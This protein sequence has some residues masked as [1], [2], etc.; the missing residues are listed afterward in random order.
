MNNFSLKCSLDTKKTIQIKLLFEHG[1]QT[2]KQT[3]HSHLDNIR[4]NWFSPLRA[5]RKKKEKF[6]KSSQLPCQ[7]YF[8]FRAFQQFF[9]SFLSLF[10]FRVFLNHTPYP[11]THKL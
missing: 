10:S 7:N 4:K 9:S 3:N 6:V 11:K 1:A 5:K 8:L 2:T